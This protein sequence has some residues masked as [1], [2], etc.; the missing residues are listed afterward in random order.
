MILKAIQSLRP[1]ITFTITGDDLSTIV[2]HSEEIT[3]P[4]QEEVD[5]KILELEE[6]DKAEVDNKATAKASLIARLGIT[7][8]ES[9]LLF[10]N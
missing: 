2:W 6:A 8:E 5:A 7:E 1:N 3:T 4:S 9:A 10:N